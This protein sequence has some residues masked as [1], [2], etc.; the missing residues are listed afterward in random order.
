V[1]VPLQRQPEE[2]SRYKLDLVGVQEVRWDKEGTVRAEDYNFFYR[3]GNDDHQSGKGFFV[4]H[5]IVSAVKRVQLVNDTVSHIVLR[6]R[7]CNIIVLNV[8]APN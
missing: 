1:Q 6:S 3:R 2:L 8:H 7:W 4:H 5:R